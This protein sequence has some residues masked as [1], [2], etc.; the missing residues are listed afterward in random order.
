MSVEAFQ[1][2]E[3][4]AWV[5]AVTATPVGA[6]GAVLSGQALAAATVLPVDERLPAAS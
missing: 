6:A 2:S 1:V 5:V 3:K 4:P